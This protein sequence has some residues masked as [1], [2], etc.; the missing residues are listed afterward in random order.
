VTPAAAAQTPMSSE[1]Q[2]IAALESRLVS[3][4]AAAAD[5]HTQMMASSELIKALAEQN[6][7]LIARIEAHRVRVLWLTWATGVAAIASIAGLALA[8][9]RY[10]G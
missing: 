7:Q 1:A 6:A 8:L 5:L 10:A 2:A 4:E 9:A 3:M